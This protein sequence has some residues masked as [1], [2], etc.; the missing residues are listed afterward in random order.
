MHGLQ[1]V[2]IETSEQALA[3]VGDGIGRLQSNDPLAEVWVLLP[4]ALEVVW[5]KRPARWLNVHS[6]NFGRLTAQ[7]LDRARPNFG[8]LRPGDQLLFVETLA[9]EVHA[10]GLDS[11]IQDSLL[12]P[13]FQRRLLAWFREMQ[14][15]AIPPDA[16]RNWA[17]SSGGTRNRDLALLYDRYVERQEQTGDLDPAAALTRVCS[18]LQ[19]ESADP[20]PV[21][22]LLVAGFAGFTPLQRHF[23]HA[24][25]RRGTKVQVFLP[26]GRSQLGRARSDDLAKELGEPGSSATAREPAPEPAFETAELSTA[27]DEVR[28][29]LRR[30]KQMLQAGE[31]ELQDIALCV[32]TMR[33]WNSLL[34]RVAEEY[35]IPLHLPLPLP[36]HPLCLA[37]RQALGAAPLFPLAETWDLLLSPWLLHPSAEHDGLEH[38]RILTHAFGVIRGREQW[39][40]PFHADA[41]WDRHLLR[42]MGLKEEPAGL[43]QD[44]EGVA[45]RL[46]DG[47]TPPDT[48][49]ER[50]LLTWVRSLLQPEGVG[51]GIPEGVAPPDRALAKAVHQAL[52]RMIADMLRAPS[53]TR[54]V[55]WPDLRRRLLDGIERLSVPLYEPDESVRV[56]D[57]DNGWMMPTRHLFVMG[58]N[59]RSLPAGAPADPVFS[60]RERD[61]HALDLRTHDHRTAWL[62]WDTLVAGCE[63]RLHLSRSRKS[64]TGGALESGLVPP[65]PFW[66]GGGDQQGAMLLPASPRELLRYTARNGAGSEALAVKAGFKRDLERI[67]TLARVD[68]LRTST[69]ALA[70]HEGILSSPVVLRRLRA[71]FDAD[72]RWSPSA[73]EDFPVCPMGFFAER[74][75][76]LQSDG[77][78]EEG[79]PPTVEGTIYHHMLERIYRRLQG[80]SLAQL[81]KEQV[82]DLVH[83]VLAEGETSRHVR[84]RYQPYPLESYDLEEIRQ[85]LIELVLTDREEAGHLAS[86]TWIPKY[87]EEFMEWT[88]DSH[89]LRE[90]GSIRLRGIVDRIDV[91]G[92][93]VLRVIDY[94]RSGKIETDIKQGRTLQAVLYG[95]AVNDRMGPVRYSAYWNV[96]NLE[97]RR[98][99]RKDRPTSPEI[100]DPHNESDPLV[101]AVLE[102]LDNIVADVTDGKFPSAPR[103]LDKDTFS[104]ASWCRK[105]EFCQPSWRSRNKGR[106]VLKSA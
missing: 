67:A 39:L 64:I 14:H 93:G 87:Q 18:L 28:W 19:A 10:E 20:E 70:C 4:P 1:V 57:F 24:V 15:Q 88:E 17:V 73:L 62:K 31:A 55:R 37:F 35:R 22:G 44:L 38:L 106:R 94:K 2:R 43:R 45:L 68:A 83:E 46:L 11:E 78:P 99:Q 36:E 63:E 59:E 75:L 47:L 51:V 8:I 42:D 9:E 48:E 3:S 12:L 27:E 85:N 76:D 30:V 71:T 26:V 72:H 92:D 69:A 90:A 61:N 29:V 82:E 104:C 101:E 105:A 74:V 81:D 65:S 32:P 95:R 103:K 56:L 91:D 80:W 54:R 66:P 100:T 98:P 84:M 60:V 16:F 52:D 5:W 21:A 97:K 40:S 7:L 86:G 53:A 96:R 89:L 23:L 49:D 58:L 41:D 33:D 79:M 6:F 25:R 77:I 50:S 102:Q 13:G 34:R